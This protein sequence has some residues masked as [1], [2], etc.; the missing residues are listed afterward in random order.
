MVDSF[1]QQDKWKILSFGLI[2]LIA[3][4]GVAGFFSDEFTP[5]ATAAKPS[6]TINVVERTNAVTTFGPGSSGI[7]FSPSC[8]SPEKETGGGYSVSAGAVVEESHAS[9]DLITGSSLNG[10]EIYVSNPTSQTISAAASVECASI[11]P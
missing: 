2:G 3:A 10:W 4:I 11:T 1:Y 8:I 7:V 6:P 5:E 9:Y